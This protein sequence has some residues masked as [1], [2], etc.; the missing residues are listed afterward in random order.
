M[1]LGMA[2]WFS[3]G[4]V[5]PQLTQEFDL[6]SSQVAWLTIGVQVG[7]VI[8]AL[9]LALTSTA[10]RIG[11]RQLIAMGAVG[12]GIVNLSLL[13]VVT[14]WQVIAARI[15]TGVCLAGVYPPAMKAI[16]TWF[17]HSRATAVAVLI[18]ALT[19]GSASPHLVAAIGG[20]DWTFVVIGTSALSVLSGVVAIGIAR[21]G[22]YPFP[23]SGPFRLDATV[24]AFAKPRVLFT[25][26]GYF[27][28]MWELYAMWSWFAVFFA[29][30]LAQNG[31]TPPWIGSLITFLVIGIGALGC[32]LGG[33]MAERIGSARVAILSMWISGACA[34]VIGWLADGPVWLVVVVA[35]V[36]GF[37]IIPD[38]PQFS[39]LITHVADQRLVGS[40][41]TLQMALGYIV[42]I[43]IVWIVPL[44]ADSFGWGPTFTL[45]AFGPALGILAM[46]KL[47]ALPVE[48]GAV[49]TR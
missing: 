45:L 16:A 20:L 10:D 30:V 31:S 44:V 41:L 33:R 29:H 14:G 47:Q 4:A 27:G 38:S 15:L 6:G 36:W 32:L 1:L 35:L 5:V 21:D 42:T 7:F 8:G 26:M 3:A 24:R 25:S 17:R 48:S 18:G 2:T 40:V 22:P 37:W 19:L 13:V 11:P 39:A 28:H 34:L 46:R 43:P 49:D 9:A 12:A 23:L